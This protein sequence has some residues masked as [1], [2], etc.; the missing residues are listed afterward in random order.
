MAA[1]QWILHAG[2]VMDEEN[3]R[4]RPCSPPR[5]PWK[6][7][8]SINGPA[9]WKQWGEILAEILVALKEGRD[10]GFK[11]FEEN[12][13]KLTDMVVKARE[14]MVGLELGLFAGSGAQTGLA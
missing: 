1:A 4:D 6:G 8:D 13:E 9:D 10:L 14:K 2:D 7:F 5:H 11:L 12:R 3:V